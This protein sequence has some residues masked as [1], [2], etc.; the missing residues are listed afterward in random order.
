MEQDVFHQNVEAHPEWGWRT[1]YVCI[2][3]HCIYVQ[4]CRLSPCVPGPPTPKVSETNL[5]LEEEAV[6]LAQSIP[7]IFNAEKFRRYQ[8]DLVPKFSQWM[9]LSVEVKMA[10]ESSNF[11]PSLAL[12][13]AL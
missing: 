2:Y 9:A 7:P 1:V 6:S 8:L 4:I 12:R 10:S 13:V 5:T 11:L 3:T